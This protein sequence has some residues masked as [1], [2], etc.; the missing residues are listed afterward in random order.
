MKKTFYSKEETLSILND[1][2]K[3]MDSIKLVQKKSDVITSIGEVYHM[4]KYLNETLQYDDDKID[5]LE[6]YIKDDINLIIDCISR[7]ISYP[8][9]KEVKHNSIKL[10]MQN[11]EYIYEVM[12]QN[13]YSDSFSKEESRD[14]YNKY[15]DYLLNKS[16]SG[17]VSMW[18]YCYI[19]RDYVGEEEIGISVKRV[20]GSNH[21]KYA[22]IMLREYNPKFKLSDNQRNALEGLLVAQ[23]L[24]K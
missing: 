9:F 3:N 22:R 5:C 11:P 16:K 20:I 10:I 6:E 15:K 13:K 1:V 8:W 12:K 21:I 18:R 2:M 17:V 23:E 24:L 14:I 7:S 19:F 4:A